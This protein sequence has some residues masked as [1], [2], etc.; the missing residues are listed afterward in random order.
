MTT[1]WRPVFAP[2]CLYFVSTTPANRRHLF[3]SEAAKRLV[4]DS[5]DCMRLR[6]RLKLY[7]FVIMP[8]HVHL[9]IQCRARDPLGAVMRDF[10]KHTADR[11]VRYHRARSDHRELQRLVRAVQRPNKQQHKVWEDNYLAKAVWSAW[12]L[13]QKMEYVHYNPCQP[14]W[15]LTAAPEDYVWSSARFYY[16]EEPAVIPVDHAGPYLL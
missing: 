8:N 2:A 1:R 5:L 11:L 10:K 7:A 6:R 12:F 16:L 14:Y 9:I 4:T 3:W 13:L 15:N